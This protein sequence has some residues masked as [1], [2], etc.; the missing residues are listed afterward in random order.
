MLSDSAHVVLFLLLVAETEPLQA[1]EAFVARLAALVGV[2][3]HSEH[4]AKAHHSVVAEVVFALAVGSA[5]I[6]LAVLKVK[7]K[8]SVVGPVS[9]A[10]VEAVE[11]EFAV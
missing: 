4:L 2:A 11:V 3:E 9:A 5:G 10:A 8:Y 1:I 7:V 6:P